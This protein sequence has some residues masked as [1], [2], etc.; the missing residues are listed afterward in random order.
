MTKYF[1]KSTVQIKEASPGS[2]VYKNTRKPFSG[3]YVHTS[4]NKFYA[5]GDVNNLGFELVVPEADLTNFGKVR[6]IKIYNLLDPDNFEDLK[7][8]FSL[9][10]SKTI[11][12]EKDYEKG[13]FLRYFIVRN[14]HSKKIFEISKTLYEDVILQETYDTNLYTPGTIRWNLVGDVSATNYKTLIQKSKKIPK[15]LSLFT[16][17]DE[18]YI[19]PN[20]AP[21]KDLQTV[22]EGRY[23]PDGEPVPPSLPASYKVPP[24]TVQQ[25]ANCIFNENNYC[26]G[27]KAEIK[28]YYWC[29]SWQVNP[30]T[31]EDT[32]IEDFM[33]TQMAGYEPPQLIIPPDPLKPFFPFGTRGR[34][35]GTMRTWTTEE[36]GD[37][38][39]YRWSG[40]EWVTTPTSEQPYRPFGTPGTRAGE[41]RRW[42]EGDGRTYKW[43]ARNQKWIKTRDIFGQ[44]ASGRTSGKG[45]TATSGGGGISGGGG[46]GY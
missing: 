27:W 46:G 30:D 14:N 22:I 28:H 34:A 5:G 3:L 13:Y 39:V 43:S 32:S 4:N 7:N 40:K 35:L 37:G 9:I 8:N 31:Y 1:P 45:G 23:Y 41:R 6:E 2:F 20:F 29:K 17:L 21:E 19:S 11:P 33:A 44:S 24:N 15:I 42:E 10:S 38:K 18:F 36:G 25:C 26:K 16:K 12:T